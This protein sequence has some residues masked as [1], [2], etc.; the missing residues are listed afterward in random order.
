MYY[1]AS[2]LLSYLSS[3]ILVFVFLVGRFEGDKI[4]II[5]ICASLLYLVMS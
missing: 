5:K 4:D 3:C 2:G 1:L